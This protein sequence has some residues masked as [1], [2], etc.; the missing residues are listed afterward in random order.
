MKCLVAVKREPDPHLRVRPTPDGRGT[1]RRTP[2]AAGRC[3]A[4]GFP[5]ARRRERH[6]RGSDRRLPGT[7]CGTWQL[8]PRCA[9]PC[10]GPLRR[11]HEQRR[12]GHPGARPACTS[13][14]CWQP[15]HDGAQHR[16]AASAQRARTAP[17]PA[18]G[19][20]CPAARHSARAGR[21]GA[22]HGASP[23]PPRHR[24]AVAVGRT[25]GGSGGRAL[26]S[27]RQYQNVLEPL[28]PRLGA[29]L[30]A[31]PAAVDAG[32]APSEAL[33]GQTGTVVA[34]ALHLAIGVSGAA[35][36][37]AGMRDSQTI[38]AINNDP[39]APSFQVADIGL[40]ADL[41][42]AVPALTQA[43]ES[44]HLSCRLTER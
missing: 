25:R 14:L 43:L 21:A 4:L 24:S 13:G 18:A 23:Y 10:G 5:D 32:H 40:V 26:G 3:H 6:C 15:G 33:V 11:G 7:A 1:G 22:Y 16:C 38:V 41:F 27:A 36:H 30:G 29:A 28:A 42:E 34:P 35:Q 9:A 37:L 2:G 20:R 12:A 19:S 39:D 44:P 8:R 17:L 31:T